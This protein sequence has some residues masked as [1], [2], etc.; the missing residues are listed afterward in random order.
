[1]TGAEM[2]IR[3]NML[4]DKIN[5]FQAD[6]LLPNEVYRALNMA[7]ETFIK[8]RYGRA[9]KYGRGF[10][11]S[12]KRIDD[13][14][15]LLVDANININYSQQIGENHFRDVICL[16]P[17]DIQDAPNNSLP[18]MFLVNVRASLKY[19]GCKVKLNVEEEDYWQWG[20][21]EETDDTNNSTILQALLESNEI[22]VGSVVPRVEVEEPL[23]TLKTAHTTLCKFVQNDDIFTVLKDPFNT[24]KLTSP[25]YSMSGFSGTYTDEEDNDITLSVPQIEIYTDSTFFV[26]TV[27]IRYIRTPDDISADQDCQLANHTHQ[28]IVNMAVD[29]LLE[30]ISDPRYKSHQA[31]T[32]K[33]D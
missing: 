21:D 7:Q 4:L 3:V 16:L 29:L 26:D 1:M 8:Q 5:S 15:P 2:L 19:V 17:N 12:Q 24:T 11:E 32:V 23:S 25:I 33:S 20:P 9:N 31:E 10:E 6:T 18:Y 27:H 14:A 13:L 30:S 28:E 22:G